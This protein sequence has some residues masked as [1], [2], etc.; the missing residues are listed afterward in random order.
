MQREKLENG[1]DGMLEYWGTD[2][3][4]HHSIIPLFHYSISFVLFRLCDLCVLCG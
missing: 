3:I 1:N 4:T 2:C